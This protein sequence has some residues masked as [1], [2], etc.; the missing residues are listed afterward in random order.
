VLCVNVSKPLA[1]GNLLRLLKHLCGDVTGDNLRDV[2]RERS[3][4]MSRS[5][6][7]IEHPPMGLRYGKLDDARQARAFRVNGGGSVIGGRGTE[8]FFYKRLGY[9]S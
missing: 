9:W 7:N 5:G 1:N 4:C 2:W 6:C 3:R 8:F